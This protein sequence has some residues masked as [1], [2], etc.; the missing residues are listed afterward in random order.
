MKGFYYKNE[1][2]YR[3]NCIFSEVNSFYIKDRATLIFVHG[4]ASPGK[5]WLPLAEKLAGR[6]NLIII[7]RPGYGKADNEPLSS[8]DENAIELLDWL[9]ELAIKG[10]LIYVGHSMGA[11]IGLECACLKPELFDYLIL[12]AP[13]SRF[14]L[15]PELMQEIKAGRYDPMIIK[16][17]FS[18]VTPS[19]IVEDFVNDSRQID[20]KS[21][22]V[23]FSICDG[24]NFQRRLKDIKPETLIIYG[25]DD[26]VVSSRQAAIFKRELN[27]VGTIEIDRAGHNL[28]L[29]Q[30]GEVAGRI[31]E[32]LEARLENYSLEEKGDK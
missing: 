15:N 10:P 31:D 28:M 17:G 13:F 22:E 21:I 26:K 16:E 30:P 8:M 29:E 23:D 24:W 19:A 5:H 6:Y 25:A 9:A 3:L 27:T 12:I 2:G 14:R 20:I 4:V 1:K 32:F 18:P 7:D 11:A